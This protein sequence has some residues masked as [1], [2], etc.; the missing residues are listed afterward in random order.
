MIEI[1]PAFQPLFQELGLTSVAAVTQFF[2][3]EP[4]PDEEKVIVKPQTLRPRTGGAV[5]VF[6]KRYHYPT[7]AWSF[8]G[9]RS[10]ARCEFVNY[11]A[12]QQLGIRTPAAVACGEERDRI[13]RLRCAFIITTA[14]PEGLGLIQFLATHCPDRSRSAHRELRIALREQLADMTRTIHAAGFFHH[15]LVW[16]NIL[17]TWNAPAAPQL[18]WID[19]PRGAF[20]QFGKERRRWRDLASLDKSALQYCSRGERLAFVKRYLG[21]TVLD[22]EA[23]TLTRKTAAYMR[24]RWPDAQP[25]RFTL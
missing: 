3:G 25:V 16:R 21:K 1:A 7:P 20:V 19:C 9:R 15:D 11:A 10:K 6:Y 18:W 22:E 2:A 5:A 4:L 8:V 13:G 17:V 12:L 24:E 23:K 14:V